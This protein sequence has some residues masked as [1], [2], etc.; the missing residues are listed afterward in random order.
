MFTSI[1][2]DLDGTLIDSAADLAASVNH[3]RQRYGLA[4]IPAGAVNAAI[5]DGVRVLLERTLL[6]ER[7]VD[8]NEALA[9]YMD[10]QREHCLDRTQLY[11]GALDAIVKLS[12]NARLGIV[13]NKP[14]ELCIQIL[15][16]LDVLKYFRACV[17]G[18][19]P[20]GRKPGA[21]PVLRALESLERTPWDA[22]V[23]GDSGPD[24]QSAAAAGAASCAVS[25]GYRPIDWLK[26]QLPDFAVSDFAELAAVA[27]TGGAKLSIYEFVGRDKFI[28]LSREFY[29]RID[30]DARLRAMFP[31]DLEEAAERQALFFI[32]FFGGPS[33]YNQ[34]RGAPKLRMRHAPF[35]IDEAA[36]RAWLENMRAAV[37]TVQL[38]EP[39]RGIFLRYVKNV[40]ATLINRA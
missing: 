20:A 39:A 36:S 38:P 15:M 4:P 26:Q 6:D 1:L 19:T 35:P 9:V 5:G 25:W 8:F 28:Q 31:P 7:K 18:D 13:S 37:E 22:L 29:K 3:A 14:T 32:Q 16:G 40:A 27:T 34:K 30:R 17:G 11:P 33:E 23:V 10:H 24:I 12:Q 2:F 21:G